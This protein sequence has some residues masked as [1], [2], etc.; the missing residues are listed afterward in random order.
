MQRQATKNDN[1][2]KQLVVAYTQRVLELDPGTMPEKD[3]MMEVLDIEDLSVE[4]IRESLTKKGV[5]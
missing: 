1:A 2:L 3:Q 4:N 5:I